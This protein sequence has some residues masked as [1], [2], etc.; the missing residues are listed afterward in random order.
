MTEEVKELKDICGQLNL[1][2]LY[3]HVMTIHEQARRQ[4][5]PH[6]EFLYEILQQEAEHRI[7]RRAA[8]RVKEARFPRIKTLSSFNFLK[9]PHLP[10]SKIRTLAEG[11]YID[12]AEPIILIGEPGTGKTHLATALGYEAAQQGHSVRFTS[13]SQL[14]NC[15]IEARDAQILSRLVSHYQKFSVLIID[16]LGY[17]PLNKTDAELIFQVLSYRQEQKPVII[18]TNLPFSEWTTV[19]PDQRLCRA[20]V[21]RLT[22]KAH[23]IETGLDSMR[24]KQTLDK[25]KKSA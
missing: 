7:T 22:H 12:A 24:L 4:Q 15:L 17:L 21:D 1:S 11:S 10:E 18:T 2:S 5:Q 23:I 20:V 8:R 19:F 14:A 3:K 9:S 25:R 16:E 6:L 13:A